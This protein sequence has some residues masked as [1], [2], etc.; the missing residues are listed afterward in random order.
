VSRWIALGCLL[1]GL[2]C[3]GDRA[4]PVPAGPAQNAVNVALGGQT[5]ARIGATAIDRALVRA[6]M[7]ARG[8]SAKAVL[9]ALVEEA[10]LAEAAIRAGAPND[11]AARGRLN[12]ALARPL[13]DRFRAEGLAAG[14]WTDDE[15]AKLGADQ[16][17]ELARP[18]GRVVVHALVKKEVPDAEQVGKRLREKLLEVSGT[19][20]ETNLKAFTEA[21]KA[22]KVPSG[23]PVHIEQL[24]FVSD[25][26]SLDS[27]GSLLPSFTKG[28]FAIPAVFGTSDLVE[29]SFGFHVIRMLAIIPPKTTTREERIAILEPQLVS[30]RVKAVH[31]ARLAALHKQ[32][33][34]QMLGSDQD[35]LLPK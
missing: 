26:R 22:F 6:V 4:A 9:D 35:L 30:A 7:Q 21:A 17:R 12:A 10:I 11:L 15:L 31:D 27:P 32:T 13:L 28:A 29:T 20:P 2:G 33:P 18:E 14:P 1:L 3:G 34:P 23:P 24:S 19:D 16:W 25:G 8:L 5:V